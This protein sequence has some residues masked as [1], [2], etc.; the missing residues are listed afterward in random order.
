MLR[1]VLRERE[2]EG[3]KDHRQSND[4]EEDMRDE[5]SDICMPESTGMWNGQMRLTVQRV[6]RDV[7]DEEEG[8]EDECHEHGGAVFADAA[9]TYVVESDE[10]RRG[11]DGIE[12]GVE[13]GEEAE[14][15]SSGVHRW[16]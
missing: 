15:R 16:V 2:K 4:R 8:R 12:Y 9:L 6:I 10:K 3:D 1:E 7:G 14:G 5:E 11:R 13:S